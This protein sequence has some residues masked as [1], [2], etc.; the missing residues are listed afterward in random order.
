MTL[1]ALVAGIIVIFSMFSGKTVNQDTRIV[2]VIKSMTPEMEFWQVV[3]DGV[4]V[5][6]RDFG[7][8]T[9]VAG[10]QSEMDIDGQIR[11]LEQLI[12]EKP[13][14]IVLAAAD[15]NRLVPVAEKIKKAGIRLITLD[16]GL[17]SDLSECF[18][19]TNN[20]D[21]GKKAANELSKLVGENGEIVLV[22]HVK[23]SAT[24]IEREKGF[25]EAYAQSTL[26]KLY[27]PVYSEANIERAS[28]QTKKLLMEHPG[29]KGVAGLNETST[30]GA[31]QAVKEL[32][33]G[34]KVKVVGFDSSISEIKLIEQGII[35]ATIIQNPFNMG[36]RG[37]EMA[38]R[39]L[40]GEK[41]SKYIDTG[42]VI[43]TRENMFNSENQKLLFP[44]VN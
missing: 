39:A 12:T 26:G 43:I 37:V 18:I 44:F 27:G 1:A 2:V 4:S 3:K 24:A 5:A 31:A 9:E 28:A 11:I 35:Q 38:V 17:N 6:G 16:S 23:G 36:Y 10:T 25:M 22:S 29:I 42:S 40:K 33:L 7:V 13:D 8:R 20:V 21:A 19:A 14:A 34:R 32:G 30:I 15:Y 41:I